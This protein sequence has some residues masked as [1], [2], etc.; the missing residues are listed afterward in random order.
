MKKKELKLTIDELKKSIIFEQKANMQ[1]CKKL[2]KS[3]F[4]LRENAAT[5]SKL[6]SVILDTFSP[7]ATAP[8]FD[9]MNARRLA[10]IILSKIR[11]IDE[12]QDWVAKTQDEAS[13]IWN[14]I[15]DWKQC[16]HVSPVSH[17]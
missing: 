15:N 1:L 8:G 13:A 14:L 3:E 6:R 10:G 2:N 9:I 4:A 17:D 5:I 11:D 16:M 12:F 7:D